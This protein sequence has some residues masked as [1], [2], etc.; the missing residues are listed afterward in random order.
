MLSS[1]QTQAQ[2]VSAP[3]FIADFPTTIGRMAFSE[4]GGINSKVGSA[5]YIFNDATGNTVHT[6][7]F[8]KTDPPTIVLK[9]ALDNAGSAAL[10][11]WHA[12]ARGGD[13]GA[14]ADGTLTVTDASGRESKIVYVVT[15]AWLSEISVTSMKAGSSDV[16]MIECKITCESITSSGK[17]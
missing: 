9:R 14:R 8:G 16:A 4:L 3:R 6:K 15:S 17:A 13:P 2:V 5:E 12:A 7:Q 11:G 10:L 1:A